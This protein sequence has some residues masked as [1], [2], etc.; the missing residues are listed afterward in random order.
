MNEREARFAFYVG[1]SDTIT[2]LL[3]DVEY[4]DPQAFTFA[5]LDL[6]P[7]A[8]RAWYFQLGRSESLAR[9]YVAASSGHTPSPWATSR[10]MGQ[11]VLGHMLG[12]QALARPRAWQRV[13]DR[14]RL[15]W[16][17][18]QQPE[19]EDSVSPLPSGTVLLVTARPRFVPFAAPVLDGVRALGH[20][21]ATLGIIPGIGDVTLPRSG[22]GGRL[23]AVPQGLRSV[24]QLVHLAAA[25]RRSLAALRPALV[26]VVEGNAP[27]DAIAGAVARDLGIPSVCLQHGWSSVVHVGYQRMPHDAMLVWGDRFGDV[28][29]PYNPGVR[30]IATGNPAMPSRLSTP[31]RDRAAVT[32]FM[33]RPTN[34]MPADVWQ[35]ILDLVFEAARTFPDHPFQVRPHPAWPL[36]EANLRVLESLPNVAYVPGPEHAMQDV[37]ARSCIGMSGYSTTLL[38]SLGA[39]VVPFI[40]SVA[41]LPRYLPDMASSGAAVEVNTLEDAQAELHRLLRDPMQLQAHEM[42]MAAQERAL[43]APYRGEAATRAAAE[44]LISLLEEARS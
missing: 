36:D 19:R 38:D 14:L 40:I 16:L 15:L 6:R 11:R 9:A 20:Q 23:S 10:V 3:D 29:K 35:A 8:E 21:A 31:L 37:M 1:I 30:F 17:G 33:Q 26:L 7:A 32:L 25:L 2:T 13:A 18:L 27:D 4:K 28:L 41:G 42:P 12:D 22:V 44:T 39:G 43:F 5:G 34:I 24:P